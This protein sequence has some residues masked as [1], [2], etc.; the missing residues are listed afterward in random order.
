MLGSTATHLAGNARC[1]LLV[2]PRVDDADGS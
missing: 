1:P 2:L